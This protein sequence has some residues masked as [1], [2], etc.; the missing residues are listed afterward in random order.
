MLKWL[1]D[2]SGKQLPLLKK[3]FCI[4]G[5]NGIDSNISIRTLTCASAHPISKIENHARAD[6]LS[7]DWKK[8]A[9]GVDNSLAR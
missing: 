7:S 5:I 3:L 4:D 6:I 1:I 2:L 9:D 8:Y